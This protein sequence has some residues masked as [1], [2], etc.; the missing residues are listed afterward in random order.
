MRVITHYKNAVVV[1]ALMAVVLTSVVSLRAYSDIL[2]I[3]GEASTGIG[4]YI[5][6]LEADSVVLDSHAREAFTPASITKALTTASAMTLL[7]KDFRFET[8]A[9]LRGKRHQD[10]GEFYGAIVIKAGGDPTLESQ[11]FKAAGFCDSIVAALQR[12]GVTSF[13][14]TIQVEN[15][16]KEQGQVE[17]W[18]IEDTPWPYGTGIYGLNYNDNVIKVF[19]ATGQ[20]SP[21]D[22]S[23]KVVKH[24]GAKSSLSRGVG[25]S[26]LNVRAP[27]RSFANKS[28]S[29][30][31]SMPDPAGVLVAALKNKM[32]AAGITFTDKAVNYSTKHPI[33]LYTHVSPPL[34][35]V[36]RSC[37]YRSDN[38]FAEALLRAFKPTESRMDAVKAEMDLWAKRG[39]DT[40][41][42][43]VLDGSGLSRGGNFSALF[44]GQVLTW[45]ARS[46][47]AAD[48]ISLFPR[49]GVSGT[50]KSFGADSRF[51]GR[52]AVK[53]GSMRGVQCYAGYM[54]DANDNPTH[55]VVVI[56]N[57][58]RCPRKTL[59]TAIINLLD[60][61]IPQD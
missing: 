36:M 44:L 43:D 39:V 38:M 9:E 22:P 28:W 25:S 33:K 1:R 5:F 46:P 45:M 3:P 32:E 59:R 34:V 57:Q 19:P 16:M 52:L 40:E 26:V 30:S 58:I 50:V 17:T 15:P 56:C 35:E 29:L 27:K 10:A 55:V 51:A 54:L 8:T 20:T 11:H 14:G 18:E 47:M 21:Y 61:F 6:D 60:N 4:L 53:S 12:R 7:G 24:I 41:Q 37:M 42:A 2:G 23:L 13:I 49:A 31:T 48:Y